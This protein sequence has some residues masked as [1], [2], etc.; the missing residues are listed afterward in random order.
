MNTEQEL[1]RLEQKI[2]SSDDDGIR[3]RWA[4][5]K[6]L[7]GLRVG[8]Q[9]PRGVLD[10]HCKTHGVSRSELSARMKF[11]EKYPTA[12]EVSTA[13]GSC[14]TWT[15][16]RKTLT[17]KPDAAQQPKRDEVRRWLDR[18]EALDAE[19]FTPEERK[20]LADTFRKTAARIDHTTKTLQPA[21]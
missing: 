5:G 21:A 11:A 8:K 9:L 15:A 14:R 18:L 13:V 19:P 2:R 4:F 12:D 16:I 10:A 7:L 3:A 1:D 20:A 6:H 17:D